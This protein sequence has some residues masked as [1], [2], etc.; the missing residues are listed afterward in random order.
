MNTVKVYVHVNK[1]ESFMKGL[2]I[3]AKQMTVSQYD[4]ELILDLSK[5]RVKEQINGLLV[6]KLK[7]Y[8]RIFKIVREDE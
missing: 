7:W 4:V 6:R 1:L 3:L 8:E 2:P 5:V